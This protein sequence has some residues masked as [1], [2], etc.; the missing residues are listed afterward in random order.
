M[1]GDGASVPEGVPHPT[2]TV[3]SSPGRDQYYWKLTR[4]I[5]P[6][7]AEELNRRLA[8]AMDADKSGWDLTQLLKLPGTPNHKYRETPLVGVSQI[9][10]E[11]YDPE[12]L[13]RI[14]PHV[15]ESKEPNR[16]ER[17][18]SQDRGGTSEGEQPELPVFLDDYGL[19][20]WRGEK[21]KRN[22]VG[23]VDRSASLL[24]MGRVLYDA[25]ATRRTIVE[26]LRER[27]E[28]LGWDKYTHRKDSEDQYHRIVDELEQ[29]GRNAN[30]T[31]ASGRK[32]HTDS[33][34]STNQGKAF[35]IG[36][37]VKLGEVIREG[38]EPP[39][40]LIERVLLKGKVH[41]VFAAPG[42]GK[43]GWP[44]GWLLC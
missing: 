35:F 18:R 17:N 26:A 5:P 29:N 43:A 2:L 19:K 6:G 13:D 39:E 42:C 3:E 22:D 23:E 30:R 20:V 40:E 25:G 16:K 1:D 38:I 14:L 28:S 11:S 27:D 34:S 36:E 8:Y 37:R 41:Q 4:L 24:L 7:K 33:F 10:G 12:E 31:F 15:D 9:S 32:R 21:I 44:F